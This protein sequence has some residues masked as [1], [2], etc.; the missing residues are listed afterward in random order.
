MDKVD[1]H[2][3]M[4]I[5]HISDLSESGKVITYVLRAAEIAEETIAEHDM[6]GNSEIFMYLS[7][8]DMLCNPFNDIAFRHHCNELIQRY[9]AGEVPMD[10]GTEVEVMM[11]CY[12]VSTVAPMNNDH[13]KLYWDLFSEIFN[14]TVFDVTG[15]HNTDGVYESYPGRK[16]ELLSIYRK[17]IQGSEAINPRHQNNIKKFRELVSAEQHE[18]FDMPEGG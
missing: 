16:E 13:A 4:M 7:P 6:R 15:D 12:Y 9:K 14:K 18:M 1:Q 5:K 10:L 11:I 3:A 2:V 8:G 17:K